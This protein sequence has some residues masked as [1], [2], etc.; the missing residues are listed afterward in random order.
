MKVTICGYHI[1][2]I[3]SAVDYHF[4]HAEDAVIRDFLILHYPDCIDLDEQLAIISNLLPS[5]W[6]GHFNKVKTQFFKIA[7]IQEQK[8]LM[9]F[10]V[11]LV[12][13]DNRVTIDEHY[14]M[15]QFVRK[16][17]IAQ[18]LEIKKN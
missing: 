1:L 4:H 2:M 8:T 3:L 18:A 14:F 5:E 6:E 15:R 9:N 12:K 17:K 11:T 13:A 16:Y 10:A 7:S